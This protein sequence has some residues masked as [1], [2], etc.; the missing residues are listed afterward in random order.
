MSDIS[1]SQY[2]RVRYIRGLLYAFSVILGASSM[3]LVVAYPFMKRFTYW[4]Q[5][6]LG[7]F[8]IVLYITSERSSLILFIIDVILV[9]QEGGRFCLADRKQIQDLRRTCN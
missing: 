1:E 4:P 3:G 7:E 6:V 8:C 9:N 2:V 5:A